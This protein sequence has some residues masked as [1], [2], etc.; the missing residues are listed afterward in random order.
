MNILHIVS[1]V[2]FAFCLVIFFYLKWY[3]KK[4]TSSSGLL[5]EYRIEVGKLIAE[6]D[7]ATDRDSQLVEERIKQLKIILDDTD[8]R[9]SVY[10]KELEKSR[11]GEALYTS[12]GRGIRAALSTETPSENKQIK[13][14]TA[15]KNAPAFSDTPASKDAYTSSDAHAS[16][17]L[18]SVRPNIIPVNNVVPAAQPQAALQEPV[19][20]PQ[21][22]KQIRAHIDLMLNEGLQPEEIASRLEISVAEVNLA[23][24]LRRVKKD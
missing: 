14:D 5:D 11:S 13:E 9:L 17:V 4:R 19:K 23:M 7:K 24:N 3:V 6:I 2:C 21:S 12:L 20:K 18:S 10:V 22:K 16:P 1:I 15:S 8:K